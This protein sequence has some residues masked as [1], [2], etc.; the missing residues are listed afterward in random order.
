MIEVAIRPWQ[1]QDAQ[2]LALI[3]NNRMVWNN[4]RDAIPN[5]YTVMDAIQWIAH[6]S[7]QKPT[8]NFAITYQGQLAG[9][10]G[11]TIQQD[12]YRKNIEIGY[13]IGESFWGKGI[14]TKAIALIIQY[15]DTAFDIHRI[16]ARV[17]AHNRASMRALEKNGFVQESIRVKSAYKNNR[18]ID[19][20]LWVR[21]MSS[22][23]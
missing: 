2:A 8:L 13:F 7:N 3:A 5:P 17:M 19:E 21:F 22:T 23:D 1:Q 15:I 6:S 11:C 10:I 20:H 12:I 9:S 14:A 4:L 18:F 16:E